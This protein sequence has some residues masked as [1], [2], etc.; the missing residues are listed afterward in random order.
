M[1]MESQM[2]SQSQ[3]KTTNQ[4]TTITNAHSSHHGIQK[5]RSVCKLCNSC[6]FS[7]VWLLLH[8]LI[9][10]STPHHDYTMMTVN[11]SLQWMIR[12]KHESI[13]CKPYGAQTWCCYKFFHI[14]QIRI[15]ALAF[16]TQFANN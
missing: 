15:R 10:A 16:L 7:I 13:T 14:K 6:C 3:D 12:I 2:E 8:D 9:P 4:K 11:I 1:L 5:Q